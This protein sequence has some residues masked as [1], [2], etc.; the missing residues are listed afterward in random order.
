MIALEQDWGFE[1]EQIP[2]R[3]RNEDCEDPVPSKTAETEV[4]RI[5][6]TDGLLRNVLCASE[7]EWSLYSKKIKSVFTTDPTIEV[8]TRD[9][10]SDEY[11]AQFD[12]IARQWKSETGGMSSVSQITSNKHYLR[13]LSMGGKVIPFIIDDLRREAAPWFTALSVLSNRYDIG[14]EYRGQFRKIANAWIDWWEN[15]GHSTCL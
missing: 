13:I 3:Y 1:D 9:Y 2:G 6:R 12:E 15:E 7:K 11:K 4:S 14:L 10:Q 5:W 8:D